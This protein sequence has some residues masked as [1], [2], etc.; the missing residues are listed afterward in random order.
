VCK[1]CETIVILGRH[2]LPEERAAAVVFLETPYRARADFAA[3]SDLLLT[4]GSVMLRHDSNASI[5]RG[6]GS[7]S[8]ELELYRA[9]FIAMEQVQFQGQTFPR[10]V[11]CDRGQRYLCRLLNEVGTS[12][13]LRWRNKMA[14]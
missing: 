9:S 4:I 12:I 6:L 2:G 1:V 5:L 11:R 3:L 7:D 8:S 13:K 14:S 10:S